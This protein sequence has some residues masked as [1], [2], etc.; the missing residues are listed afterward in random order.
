MM[1]LASVELEKR[2]T[3]RLAQKNGSGFEDRSF[4]RNTS[5]AA[6]FEAKTRRIEANGAAV[7]G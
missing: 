2:V 5:A 4:T 1:R 6:V 3:A 7:G